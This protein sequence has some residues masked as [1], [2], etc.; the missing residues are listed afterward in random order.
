MRQLAPNNDDTAL[1]WLFTRARKY[2]LLT[3]AQEQEIDRDKW[4]AIEQLLRLFVADDYC[5]KYLRLWARAIL[6]DELSLEDF[7]RREHYNL[8]KR[9]LVDLLPGGDRHAALRRFAKCVAGPR[10]ETRDCE[11]ILALQLP[12]SLAVGLAETLSAESNPRGVAAALQYWHPFWSNTPVIAQHGIDGQAR[13]VVQGCL[14][15]YYTSREKLVNHNLRLAFSI[16]GRINGR[17]VAYR[18]LIQN[19]V[20]GLIRAAEKFQHQQGY[21][22]STY[23]YNWITQSMRQSIEDSHGIVRYPAGVNEKISRMHRERMQLL[24]ATGEEPDVTTLAGRLQMTPEAL[25]SLQQV[26]N[27]SISLDTKP[28]GDNEGLALG[29]TL[30]GDALD[31]TQDDAEHASLNRCLMQRLSILEPSEQRVVIRRWGLDAGPPL[32]RAQIASQLKVSAEWVRQ[33]ENS[34]LAK[35]RNDE[36]IAQAY[37]DHHGA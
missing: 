12:A 30:A 25:R 13:H 22:F 29:E 5:R 8:L 10:R 11:A 16:A 3:A 27:L 1:D 4:Q 18:D 21:R 36:G 28:D 37:R 24:S 9:E 7:Q 34:A 2:P 33:L 15:D 23:A 6:E 14:T 35:L 32:T 17:G 20:L 19:G 31:P 26:G